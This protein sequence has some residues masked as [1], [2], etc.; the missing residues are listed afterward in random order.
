MA[1]CRL[2]PLFIIFTSL[3]VFHSFCDSNED[4]KSRIAKARIESCGG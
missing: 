2:D 4:K 1:V 3:F